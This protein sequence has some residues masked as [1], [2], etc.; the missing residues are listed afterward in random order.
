MARRM[1]LAK[2]DSWHD[3]LLARQPLD[4]LQGIPNLSII[5]TFRKGF[6]VLQIASATL[7][8]SKLT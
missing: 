2:A 7:K 1:S 5:R 3:W 4:I 6:R 8:R